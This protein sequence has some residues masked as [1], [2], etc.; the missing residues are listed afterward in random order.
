[1]GFPSELIDRIVASEG[2]KR[3]P[4]R[5]SLGIETIGIGHN[6]TKP[7]SIGACDYILMDDI[8]DA[9]SQVDVALPWAAGLGDVR[10]YSLVELAFNLG[11]GV[12]GGTHGLLSFRH[13]L[14][15]LKNGQFMNA[16]RSFLQ[17]RWADEVGQ[18]RSQR[19]CQQ[20]ETNEWA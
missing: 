3:L 1:V 11:I 2:V 15:S 13:A 4:Y 17:S 20:L 16:A 6:L 10:Y 7:L 14:E 19:I 18:E 12:A 5:D 8:N 9:K